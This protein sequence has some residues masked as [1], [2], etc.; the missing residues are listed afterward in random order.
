MKDTLRK[1]IQYLVSNAR[2]PPMKTSLIKLVYMADYYHWQAYGCQLTDCE[3]CLGR[4]G[5]IC[6]DIPD[7]AWEM[8]GKE[9]KI[10]TIL[11]PSAYQIM[12]ERIPE[13]GL[14][15]NLTSEQKEILDTVI[16]RHSWQSLPILKKAHYETEPMKNAKNIG[17]N[18]D[19][20]TIKQIPRT[21]NNS[22][23]KALQHHIAEMNLETAGSPEERSQH[24][25]NLMTGL[26]QARKRANTARLL[27]E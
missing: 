26:A 1:A 12:Y 7:T 6:F 11:Y 20:S 8:N 5:A 17:D 24:Y 19:M 18:L 3:Y 21:K 22:R 9:L 15:A 14:P 27:G 4:Y 25:V 23:I 16:E 10:T 2:Y 13:V